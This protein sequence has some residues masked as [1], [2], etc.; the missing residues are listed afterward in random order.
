MRL[1]AVATSSSARRSPP[2]PSWLGGGQAAGLGAFAA[3][4][5]G[6]ERGCRL[7]AAHDLLQREVGLGDDPDHQPSASS[8]TGTAVTRC[9]FS[10]RTS[11]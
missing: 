3:V 1:A 7:R 4:L 6:L 11:P 10:S 9:S 5:G 2:G 8:S